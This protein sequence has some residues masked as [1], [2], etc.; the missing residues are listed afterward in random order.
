MPEI[1][2]S[3]SPKKPSKRKKTNN[4]QKNSKKDDQTEA[5]KHALTDY[6]SIHANKKNKKLNNIKSLE[7]L[8]QQYMNSF[9]LIGYTQ[10][11]QELIS[12]VNATSEQSA[13]SLSAALNKFLTTGPNTRK[14]PN[15]L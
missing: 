7:K 8:I 15:I 6:L 10:D 13:D 9:I 4:S 14:P 11:T 3:S 5:L 12:L 2:D 1:K